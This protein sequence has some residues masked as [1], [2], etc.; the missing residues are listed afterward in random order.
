[1]K[2]LETAFST[3]ITCSRDGEAFAE[4]LVWLTKWLTIFVGIVFAIALL[5]GIVIGARKGKEKFWRQIRL[6]LAGA[7]GFL[8]I[9]ALTGYLYLEISYSR[10]VEA[11]KQE[12]AILDAWVA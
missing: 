2:L 6:H 11:G 12:D 3:A 7:V 9:G 10:A 8:V 4:G 5:S 1:M